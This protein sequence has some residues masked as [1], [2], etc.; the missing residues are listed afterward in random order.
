MQLVCQGIDPQAPQVARL[1]SEAARTYEQL[2]QG[3]FYS[4]ILSNINI[5]YVCCGIRTLGCFAMD[6]GMALGPKMNLEVN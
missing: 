1:G 2:S 3:W 6:Q 4:I 5:F